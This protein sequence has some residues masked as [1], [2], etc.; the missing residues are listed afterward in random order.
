V[1]SPSAALLPGCGFVFLDLA[2]MACSVPA[3]VRS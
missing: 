3:A 2:A 1:S